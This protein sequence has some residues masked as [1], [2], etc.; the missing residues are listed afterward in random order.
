MLPFAK[1]KALQNHNERMNAWLCAEN[2]AVYIPLYTHTVRRGWFFRGIIQYPRADAV[3][4]KHSICT[5]TFEQYEWENH[6]RS[7]SQSTHTRRVTRKREIIQLYP[8]FRRIS[9]RLTRCWCIFFLVPAGWTTVEP[10]W[11]DNV[12][13]ANE[14]T[15]K[16]ACLK[17]VK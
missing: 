14:V 9:A 13:F 12:L 2:S 1:F 10:C 17:W 5:G 6:H 11:F 8:V 16:K 15:G 7:T 3:I 4:P